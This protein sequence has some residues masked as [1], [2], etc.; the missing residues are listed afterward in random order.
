MRYDKCGMINWAKNIL[1]FL[2]QSLAL[3]SSRKSR[4]NGR[5]SSP[6]NVHIAI[7]EQ[8]PE[9][10]KFV[11]TCTLNVTPFVIVRAPRAG[12]VVRDWRQRQV[13][14]STTA[15]PVAHLPV[16]QAL[17][18]PVSAT[19]LQQGIVQPVSH[20]FPSSINIVFVP[21]LRIP[22]LCIRSIH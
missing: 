1:E 20:V 22:L 19:S 11:R 5:C 10:Y 4:T 8:Y 14:L 6:K 15:L 3:Y 2:S 13:N 9:R 7:R 12:Q 18:E 16:L 17:L 21:S